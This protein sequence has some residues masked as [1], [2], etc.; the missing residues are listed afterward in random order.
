L[1]HKLDEQT[2]KIEQAT[3]ELQNCT[4]KELNA[5]K[6]VSGLKKSLTEKYELSND[7]WGY[8]PETLEI[9]V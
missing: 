7:V 2:R 3:G 5:M 4:I 8:D 6:N 1:L 9:K